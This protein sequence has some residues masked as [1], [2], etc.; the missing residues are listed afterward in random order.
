ML[1]TEQWHSMAQMWEFVKA[2]LR[3]QKSETDFLNSSLQKN[4]KSPVKV[5][6]LGVTRELFK[7]NWPVGSLVEAVDK[8]QAMID[9][10]WLGKKECAYCDNWLGFKGVSESY[11]MILCDG[12]LHLV[13]YPAEQ[14]QLLQ[15]IYRLLKKDG[16][17]SFRFFSPP[18]VQEFSTNL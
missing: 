4:F 10:L 5:L 16:L 18:R 9:A 7:L 12:G 14:S 15:N 17:L 3:P 13:N 6:I 2:P 1:R 11:D 8:S